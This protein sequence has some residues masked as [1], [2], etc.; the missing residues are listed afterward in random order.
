M[1]IQCVFSQG[2]RS[3]WCRASRGSVWPRC[4]IRHRH[5][6]RRRRSRDRT[7][8]ATLCWHDPHPHFRRSPRSLRPHR[9]HLPVHKMK[10]WEWTAATSGAGWFT[11][12]AFDACGCGRQLHFRRDRK[13]SII[14]LRTL[15]PQPQTHL[16]WI[17]LKFDFFH[18]C[19]YV[20]KAHLA[21]TRFT[22]NL[23]NPREAKSSLFILHSRSQTQ[24][25]IF[26][27]IWKFSFI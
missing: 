19:C 2:L 20:K 24:P 1:L 10:K 27:I 23:V 7:A 5:R 6:W 15:L 21:F 4:R 25:D 8:A 22:F 11:W 13:F 17:S 14:P 16:M 9:R 3:P 18:C 12:A 26:L